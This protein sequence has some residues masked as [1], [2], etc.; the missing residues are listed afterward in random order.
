MPDVMGEPLGEWGVG[1]A[2]EWLHSDRNREPTE[3]EKENPNILMLDKDGQFQN[4]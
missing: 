1:G 4:M 3:F 2:G